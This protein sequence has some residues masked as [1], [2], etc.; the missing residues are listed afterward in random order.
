[1]IFIIDKDNF[2]MKILDEL[3]VLPPQLDPLKVT[4]IFIEDL[5]N[6]VQ[7]TWDDIESALVKLLKDE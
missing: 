3:N 6:L 5:Q 2:D 1:M 7:N 4:L